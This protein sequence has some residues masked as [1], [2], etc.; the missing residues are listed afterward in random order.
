MPE[1]HDFPRVRSY[2]LA[3]LAG[4]I[5]MVLNTV[6]WITV[7]SLSK[8][9]NDSDDMFP[10]SLINFSGA[11]FNLIL[12]LSALCFVACVI[13]SAKSIIRYLLGA[14][15]RRAIAFVAAGVILNL[16]CFSLYIVSKQVFYRTFG[17]TYYQIE[18]GRRH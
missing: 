2:H 7:V 8:L 4:L 6:Y 5:S 15:S 10:I 18:Y 12:I 16:A 11:Y 14:D 1:Y 9:R 3:F 17:G 13:F